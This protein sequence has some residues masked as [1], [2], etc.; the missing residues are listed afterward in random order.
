MLTVEGRESEFARLVHTISSDLNPYTVLF[1]LERVGAVER[2]R[3][4]VKLARRIFVP[5]GDVAGGLG[6]LADDAADLF[7]ALDENIFT[8]AEVPNLHIKTQY[9]NIP[10]EALPE[11]RAWLFRE[12]SAFHQR[13][14]TFF[15]N[16]DRDT[17]R[18]PVS[19][20]GRL[21]V[22]LGSFSRVSPHT[23]N[24]QEIA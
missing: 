15:G 2:T 10:V 22:A 21:R 18:R 20:S 4:G 5:A 14:R 16:L 1:E 9:D 23:G 24:D 6:L 19:G 12:G 3:G 7:A 11:V 13:A 17:S 8:P